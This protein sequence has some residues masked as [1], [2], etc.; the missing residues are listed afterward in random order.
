MWLARTGNE[1]L[2][3]ADAV[4][5]AS[6][7][8]YFLTLRGHQPAD[9]GLRVVEV[10]VWKGAWIQTFLMNSPLT[11]GVGIDPYPFA[12]G[13]DVRE[14]MLASMASLG[15]AGRFRLAKD[16]GS[17]QVMEDVDVIHVDGAHTEHAARR[18]LKR[19]AEILAADGMIIVDDHRHRWYPGVTYGVFSF[20]NETDFF[21]LADSANK[22]YLVR[23]DILTRAREALAQVLESTPLAVYRDPGEAQNCPYPQV[24]QVKGEPV[25]LIEPVRPSVQSLDRAREVVPPALWRGLARTYYGLKL[26]RHSRRG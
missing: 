2:A 22:A 12:S 8:R 21:L 7:P 16:W 15:L 17:A 23:G 14:G 25:M 26:W 13:A 19:A 5:T 20:L 6:L 3:H 11:Q 24:Q 10:G 9:A 1:W 18:D 4:L